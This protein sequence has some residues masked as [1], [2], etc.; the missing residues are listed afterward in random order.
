MNKRKK[1]KGV[2]SKRQ[3]SIIQMLVQMHEGPVTVNAI[4]EKLNVSSRT[5][6]RDMPGIE[7]WLEEN[8]FNFIK[9]P[10]V[11]L[12]IMESQEQLELIGELLE[13]ENIIP[14]YSRDE[15]RRQLLG[16]LFFSNEPIKSYVFTSKYNI[17]EG[18]LFSDLDS[19]DIWLT[20]Y[21]MKVIRR[22]GVGIF[23]EGKESSLRQAISNAVFEFCN[24]DQVVEIL[25][26]KQGQEPDSESKCQNPLL[27]FITPGLAAFAEQ[28]IE[29]CRRQLKVSYTDSGIIGLSVRIA[30]TVYRMQC[31][32]MLSEPVKDQKRLE[33]LR[34]Y[35]TARYICSE[36]HSAFDLDVNS[37]ETGYLAMFLSSA[38]IWSD[39]SIFSDPMQ[40]LNLRQVVMSMTSIVEQLTG[41]PF[42]SSSSLIDDL[43]SHIAL[44]TKRISMDLITDDANGEFVRTN[45][46]ELYRAVETACHALRELI[47]PKEISEADIGYISMHFAATAE[48]IQEKSRHISVAVVCPLGIGSSR[49][50]AASL[51]RSFQC[52]EIRKMLSAFDIHPEQ[53]HREG[54]DLIISTTELHTDFPFVCVGKVLQ[55][56]DRLKIQNQ[57]DSINRTRLQQKTGH[58]SDTDVMISLEDI[59]RTAMIGTEIVEILNNFRI[60]P[61]ESV[62][63]K[64]ELI[65]WAAGVFAS[66]FFARKRIADGFSKREELGDTYIQEMGI[67][68]FH[69]RTDAMQHSRF[70]Y[71]RLSHPLA[72]EKGEIRGAVIMIVPETIKDNACLEPVGRLSALLIENEGFLQALQSC[73]TTAGVALAEAALVKYYQ[74]TTTKRKGGVR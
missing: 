56:Q 3:K 20:N 61:V 55:V 67:C 47:Y 44:M 60:M 51:A 35:E 17:S 69:C 29:V 66:D 52:I 36:I 8:D 73:D 43:V 59:N 71:I 2:L 16:E 26:V 58:G 54:I 40:A 13:V 72:G 48:Q 19:L 53:L 50:L 62:K 27:V 42:R 15:R 7:E 30:L 68:L 49:M 4:S 21:Q 46:P 32:H 70:G 9:K 37:F 6:L 74:N 25:S 22:P 12:Q 41:L 45:Y 1:G 39:A 23:L 63:N 57:I 33:T 14:M 38:R 11:G 18:T 28:M 34:E 65:D 5:V 31:G 10:G 64:K 24:M